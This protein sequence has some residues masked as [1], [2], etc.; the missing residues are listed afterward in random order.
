MRSIIVC[1]LLSIL[2]LQLAKAQDSAQSLESVKHRYY[3][4]KLFLTGGLTEHG[5]LMG[6]HDSAVYV[7]VEKIH[8]GGKYL[9]DPFHDH[10]FKGDTARDKK[11]FDINR[12][13]CQM[14]SSIRVINTKAKTWTVVGCAVAGII[15]GAVIGVSQG[16]DQGLFALDAAAKGIALGIVGGGIG[17]LVGFA[18]A[19]TED[20]KYLVNGNWESL[21][22]L[23]AELKY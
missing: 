10:M 22:E 8:Y 17:T 20:K 16:P 6:I 19:A 5:Y 15:I 14:L 13:D 12:Y 23:K 1:L 4:V 7:S 9:P 18:I 11:H 3:K 21:Q 2:F